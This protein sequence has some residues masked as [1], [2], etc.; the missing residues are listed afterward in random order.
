MK[1]L[2]DVKNSRRAKRVQRM[3]KQKLKALT[4]CPRNQ[5]PKT[6]FRDANYQS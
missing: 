1:F 5:H 4:E 6:I 3:K 2:F